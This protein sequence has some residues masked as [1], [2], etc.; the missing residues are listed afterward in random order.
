MTGLTGLAAAFWRAERDDPKGLGCESV[1]PTEGNRRVGVSLLLVPLVVAIVPPANGAQP[2][3]TVDGKVMCQVQT[4]MRDGTLLG[5]AIEETG[6][7][8]TVTDTGV[9]AVWDGVEGSFRRGKKGIWSACFTG[10]VTMDGALDIVTAIDTAYGRQAQEAV[11]D[12]IRDRAP[13]IGWR[14]ESEDVADDG[15]VRRTYQIGLGASSGRA[16]VTVDAAGRSAVAGLDLPETT[17]GAFLEMAEKLT[18]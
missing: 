14:P 12:R 11:L 1:R 7:A 13:A 9:D 6:A 3:R 10:A 2:D 8:V 15:T 5:A 4:R 16:V 17:A 18:R